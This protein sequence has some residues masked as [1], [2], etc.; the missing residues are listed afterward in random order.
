MPQYIDKAAVV[1]EI[2]RLIDT[3]EKRINNNA[4][5]EHPE[6]IDEENLKYLQKTRESK[7]TWLDGQEEALKKV[8]NF[9]DTLEVKEV[10]L[11][12][13]ANEVWDYVFSAL[14]WDENSLMP[15]NHKEYMAF[16]KHFFELGVQVSNKA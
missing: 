14:G 2:E 3:A 10:D 12:K 7:I 8:K 6:T 9:L 16:A 13:E 15:L 4:Q 5:I 11:E 1:A